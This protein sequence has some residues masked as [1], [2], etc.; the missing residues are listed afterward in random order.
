[1]PDAG[2]DS[3]SRRPDVHRDLG[4]AAQAEGTSLDWVFD[5]Q[6]WVA[7]LTLTTLEIVLGVDNLVFISIA[8]NIELAVLSQASRIF[9]VSCMFPFLPYPSERYL[10]I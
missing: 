9:F 7:L 5:S 8:V 1:M 4:D 3:G 2:V 10:S 6:I